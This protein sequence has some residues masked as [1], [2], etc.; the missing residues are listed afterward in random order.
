MKQISLIIAAGLLSLGLAT[1]NAQ[2]DEGARTMGE[3]LRLIEQGQVRDSQ[4]A[5]RRES[6]FAQAKNKQQSLLN[7][8]R[9]ERNRQEKLSTNLE[10]QFG[11]NQKKI[12]VAR[13]NLDERLGALKELFGVLQTVSGDAQGRFD[14]SLTNIQFPN[15]SDFL[16]KLGSKMAGASS[17]ASIEDIE[18]LWAML[19]REIYETGRVVRFNHLVTQANGKQ[20]QTEII[21]VGAFNIVSENGY[22][23]YDVQEGVITVSELARQPEGRYTSTT[24]DMMD[25]NSG[26]VTFGLDV[27]RGTILGLLVES[28]TM[29][30][31]IEQGGIVGY[32]I[33]VLGFIGLFIA[34]WRLIGLSGDSRRVAAQLKR[35]TASTDNPLGR[36]LAAYE[37]NV[38]ADT[39]TIELKA[40]EAGRNEMPGLNTGLWCI[41]V[42]SAVAPLMGLLG[43]VTGMIKTFQVI[44]L[45]GA[46]DPKMMAGGI[47]QALMTTVLGLVVA[48]PM[49]LLHTIVSGQSRKIVN[50]IQSQSAGLVAE[51]SERKG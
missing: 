5:R 17:L 49:V 41:K 3:L 47:S 12:I 45:Y 2:D 9:A 11:T 10:Q 35:D 8:A 29:R 51:H 36:G 28:P 27:T 44:T 40:T 18:K 32:C 24:G 14:A 21:R 38:N 37:N 15:R 7:K 26:V 43:T 34:I 16:V 48:I 20:E 22:L 23:K 42:V 50:I 6:A 30:D 13:Q 19:Q 4:E 46:G 25:A 39:G 31:R 33:I 1:A